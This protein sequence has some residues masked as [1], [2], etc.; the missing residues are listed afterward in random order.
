MGPTASGKTELALHLVRHLPLEIINV[1][2][3][4]VY[5]GMDIGTAKPEQDVLARVPH[6]LIDIRD[7]VQTY[8]AAEFRADALA[9]MEEITA[10][11]RIPLLAGGTGLYFRA[12]LYGLSELPSADRKVRERLEREA[13]EYG[14]DQ[15]HRRLADVDPDAAAR[16]HPNDPQRIQRALEVYELTGRPISKLQRGR[17]E[18]ILEW[19]VLKLARAT[20]NREILHRRIEKRFR[21]MLEQGFEQEVCALLAHGDLGP[22]TPSMRSV[23]YRQMIRYLGGECDYATMVEQGIIATR[24][25]AK[26]QLTWLRAEP[27]VHWLYDEDGDPLAAALE[28]VV[29]WLDRGR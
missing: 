26:R 29:R 1:D 17:G 6:R 20:R 9:A 2:S 27:E 23:G 18:P 7:P 25:L 19:R 5:R 14:L 28:L 24:Q 10:A 11:G 21:V 12:L 13:A 8:S 22:D 16:I 15:M 3:A 4:Q